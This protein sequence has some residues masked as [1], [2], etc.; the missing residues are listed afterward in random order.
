[1]SRRRLTQPQHYS[2]KALDDEI[3]NNEA[4]FEMIQSDELTSPPKRK[5]R[6]KRLCLVC[7]VGFVLVAAIGFL[8]YVVVSGLATNNVASAF[9]SSSSATLI[10]PQQQIV[11]RNVIPPIVTFAINLTR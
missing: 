7:S 6:F 10:A 11:D 1:M 3:D 8:V 4:T 9:G 5:L 2:T